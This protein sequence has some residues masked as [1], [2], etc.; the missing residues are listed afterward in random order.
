MIQLSIIIPTYNRRSLLEACLN[1]LLSQQS[2]GIEVVVIDDGSSDDTEKLNIL[3][4]PRVCYLKQSNAGAGAAR[5]RGIQISKGRYLAFL[6]S[7]DLWLPWTWEVLRGLINQEM[8]ALILIRPVEFSNVSELALVEQ[9]PLDVRIFEDYFSF[10]DSIE[11]RGASS[12][13]VRRDELKNARFFTKPWNAEDADFLMQ[14]GDRKKVIYLNKPLAYGFRCHG[15]TLKGDHGKNLDGICG[16]ISRENAG[17]YP[18]GRSRRRERWKIIGRHVRPAILDNSRNVHT[19][20]SMRIYF[21]WLPRHLAEFRIRF[22]IGF[23]LYWMRSLIRN[24]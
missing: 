8:P 6:D 18:G 15:E 12:I 2:E 9:E 1:S 14:L 24:R 17:E 21:K 4:D 10:G 11:F 3:T 16:I 7:D 19:G 22:I 13:I 23:W 5:N 20:K